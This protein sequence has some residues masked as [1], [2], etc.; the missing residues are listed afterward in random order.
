MKYLIL[1]IALSVSCSKQTDPVALLH[2]RAAK[3]A[4]DCAA[5]FLKTCST[6][7]GA[8]EISDCVLLEC[9]LNGYEWPRS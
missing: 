9:F 7:V 6:N 1:V 3:M 8:A 4:D 5:K 2:K